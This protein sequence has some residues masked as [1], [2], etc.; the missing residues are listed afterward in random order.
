MALSFLKD[1]PFAVEAFFESSVVI[2][3]AFPAGELRPF[4]PACLELDT[5]DKR[6]AFLAVAMVQTKRL[7]PMGFPRFLGADFFLVGYRVFVRFTGSDRRRSRG[8][9]ILGSRSDSRRMEFFG[10]IF[11]HYKYSTI[12]VQ[13]NEIDGVISVSSNRD[14]FRLQYELSHEDIPLPGGSPFS[15]WKEARR[16]AGP[17]PFTYTY[18]PN[19]KRLLVIEGVRE[20][21]KPTPAKIVDHHFSFL[22]RL[23]IKGGHLANAFIVHNIPYYWKKGRLERIRD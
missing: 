18:K 2:A 21:W 13:R 5:F 16:F 11:T 6:W 10:N 3:Y 4:I 9:Y 14:G 23:G 19:E 1:H 20:N 15:N 17:L 8:L 22:D 12:D 7:R